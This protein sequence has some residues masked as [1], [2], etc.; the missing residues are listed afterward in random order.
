M[1]QKPSFKRKLYWHMAVFAILPLCALLLFALAADYRN[2][3][4]KRRQ[5]LQTD[6]LECESDMMLLRSQAESA[7]KV[8][9]ASESISKLAQARTAAEW[10]A[11]YNSGAFEETTRTEAY[12]TGMNATVVLIFQ[13]RPG[14]A[15]FMRSEHWATLLRCDRYE[16]ME[17]FTDFM[18]GSALSAWCGVAA[19]LPDEVAASFDYRTVGDRL[20]YLCRPGPGARQTDLVMEC[21][22]STDPFIACVRRRMEEIPCSLASNGY[23]LYAQGEMPEHGM[24]E[25]LILP[26]LGMELRTC[27][28]TCMLAGGYLSSR[29]AEMPFLLLAGLLLTL[30][31]RRRLR[32]LLARMEHL[33]ASADQIRGDRTEQLPDDGNDEVGRVIQAINRLLKRIEQQSREQVRQEKDKRRHQALALQYQLNPHF[34]F[35]SLQWVQMEMER[36]GVPEQQTDSIALLAKV[37][38]YNLTESLTAG[39][40]DELEHVRAYASFM[41][42]MKQESILLEADCPTELAEETLPRFI[43]QPLVENALQHGLIPGK[44]LHVLIQIRSEKAESGRQL[45]LRVTNDGSLIPEEQLRRIQGLTAD[46]RVNTGGGY[47]LANLV[48]RLKLTYGEQFRMDAASSLADG[49]PE[50]V[51][52]LRIP[53]NAGIT[54]AEARQEEQ[55]NEDPDR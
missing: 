4:E 43:L 22:L 26:G 5:E 54:P 20:I 46:P 48:Q 49:G 1:K 31:S 23:I 36:Q 8:L 29:R 19:A 34:L 3:S 40:R 38:R 24:E 37:L 21:A 2:Y 25:A 10:T 17:A 51:F 14:S 28:S 12:L 35:N 42:E 9:T 6:L 33:A 15:S 52:S 47:G 45:M 11:A 53:M 30:F 44:A 50:T 39:L 7:M 32:K 16:G 13:P 18:K 41:A 55:M 27:V